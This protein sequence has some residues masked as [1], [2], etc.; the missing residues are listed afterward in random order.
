MKRINE[1]TLL[2]LIHDCLTDNS[3]KTFKGDEV[4]VWSE[5]NSTTGRYEVF[6][7]IGDHTKYTVSISKQTYSYFEEKKSRSECKNCDLPLTDHNTTVSSL[8]IGLCQNCDFIRAW[9]KVKN[10]KKGGQ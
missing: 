10:A 3:P 7:K 5:L 8:N 1:I 4:E 2:D 6:L 9:G